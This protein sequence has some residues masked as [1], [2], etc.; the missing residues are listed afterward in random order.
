MAIYNTYLQSKDVVNTENGER[1]ILTFSGDKNFVL[2]EEASNVYSEFEMIPV[3][4]DLVLM[5]GGI[6]AL[7]N[8]S[9]SW[10]SNRVDYYLTSNDLSPEE[11]INVAESLNTTVFFEK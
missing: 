9:L 7:A 5:S 11:A 10:S 1:Y 8:N 3:Y 2:I 6:G 4:G